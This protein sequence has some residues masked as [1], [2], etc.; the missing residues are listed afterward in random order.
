MFDFLFKKLRRAPNIEQS[1]DAVKAD[2]VATIEVPETK[3]S[4]PVLTKET[5]A[6]AD[7][8]AIIAVIAAAVA[9]ASGRDPSTFRVVSFKRA[10]TNFSYKN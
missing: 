10:N 9:A 7:D 1:A 6:P 5:T 8:L 3:D 2:T 4:A